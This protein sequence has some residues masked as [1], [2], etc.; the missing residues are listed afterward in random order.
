VRITI[1]PPPKAARKGAKRVRKP[2]LDGAWLNR[3]EVD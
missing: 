3:L 1:R 2:S